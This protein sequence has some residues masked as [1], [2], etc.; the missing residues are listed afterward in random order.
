MNYSKSLLTSHLHMLLSEKEKKVMDFD[1][2]E[3]L[4]NANDRLAFGQN[5][6][7]TMTMFDERINDL[8]KAI[9]KLEK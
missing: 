8:K 6:T 7:A 2:Q 1:F 3:R 5:R 4:V 9:E